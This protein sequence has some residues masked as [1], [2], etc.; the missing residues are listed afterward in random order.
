M[1]G[2]NYPPLFESGFT[3]TYR[4]ADI[5]YGDCTKCTLHALKKYLS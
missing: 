2:Y 4:H 3:H 5:H 1:V